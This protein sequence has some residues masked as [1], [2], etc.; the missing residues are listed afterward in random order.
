MFFVGA[1]A[2]AKVLGSSSKP[3]NYGYDDD[4]GDYNIV[5]NDHICYRFEIVDKL[6][7]G[8]FGQAVKCFDHKTRQMVAVKIIRNKKRFQH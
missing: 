6:G 5:I 2:A 7:A 3:N 4:R 8:S 1:A